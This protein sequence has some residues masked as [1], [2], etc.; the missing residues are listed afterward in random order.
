MKKGDTREI[1]DFENKLTKKQKIF[2]DEFIKTGSRKLSAKKAYNVKNEEI[3]RVIASDNLQKLNIR[4]YI[5]K[6]G[7][8]YEK[9][10]FKNFGK[11]IYA[12]K[13]IRNF[14]EDTGEW[15]VIED[16]DNAIQMKAIEHFHKVVGVEKVEKESQQ[17]ININIVNIMEN[18]YGNTN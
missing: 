6:F 11:M 9:D 4:N 10:V 2:A 16:D 5:E 1:F 13:K 18:K 17:N 12:K 7:K 3:A 8:R 14:R 15:E